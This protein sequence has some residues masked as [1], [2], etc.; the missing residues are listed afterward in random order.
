MNDPGD[1]SDP[2]EPEEPGKPGEPGEYLADPWCLS[3]EPAREAFRA[4]SRP[5]GAVVLD[6]DGRTVATG[7][8]RSQEATAPPR[9]LATA[10]GLLDAPTA[11]AAYDLLRPHL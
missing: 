5:L 11:Q 3:F 9:Q 10:D 6:A 8:N 1:P 7:R 4:G 2:S